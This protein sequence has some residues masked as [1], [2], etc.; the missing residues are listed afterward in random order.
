[1]QYPVLS[2]AEFVALLASLTMVEALAG[3]IMLPG[4]PDIGAAFEVANPNDR[5]LVLMVFGLAFGLSQ[6]IFG[7]LSDRYGRRLPILGGVLVYVICSVVSVLA[8]RFL[9]LLLIR[10]VQGV[11]SAAVKVAVTAAVRDRYEG[12]EMAQVTSLMM[13][14]FLLVPVLM[15]SAGQALLLVGPWQLIF[16]AMGGLALVIGVWAF[17]RFGDTLAVEN[18]RP[19]SFAGISEGF[20][21]VFSN[22]RAFFYG[23]TGMFL[24]GAVLGMIFT[25][26]QVY[27]D[28]Y[29]W[30]VWYPLAMFAMAGSASLC[31][32]AVARW[33]GRFG[34]R[35]AA[36]AALLTLPLLTF[37]G[38]AIAA[39]STLPSWAYLTICCLAAAPLVTGF[40]STGALSMQ[41]L[42]AVAGTAASVFGLI[43]SVFGTAFSYVITQSFNGTPV[44]V[45]AGMGILGMCGLAFCAIAENGRLFGRDQPAEGPV[46]A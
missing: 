17:F 16:Y 39:T 24:M 30:G 41:P 28:V 18:R 35:R 45:L 2:K 26:Q 4:L 46:A 1:M 10:F 22:R 9:V 27:V 15:P 38:A 32:L 6:P 8:P 37:T 43:A 34:L 21:L 7:P 23:S 5:S 33:L 3:D 42:G 44:P 25:S 29:G 11:A 31:S 14:I 20:A 12:N 13:S 36:H 19:L 40:A